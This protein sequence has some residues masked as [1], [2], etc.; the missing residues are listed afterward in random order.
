[1]T[2]PLPPLVDRTLQ[3]LIRAFA[4]EEIL[5][6]GSWAKGT[7]H[8]RSDV[9]LLI[10]ADLPG[11]PVVHARRAR[12]LAADSFPRIDIVFATP[13]EVAAAPTAKSP[14]LLSIL[15][16]GITVYRR[17]GELSQAPSSD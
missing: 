1:M 2:Q 6:F 4:P 9:D 14:F 5:L 11:S 3:R 10:I 15:G 13:A 17:R 16:T 7:R 8:V 12:Q